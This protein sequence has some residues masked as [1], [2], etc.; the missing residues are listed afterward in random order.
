VLAI[1]LVAGTAIVLGQFGAAG[2]QE[3]PAQ[4]QP[5]VAPEAKPA[6]AAAGTDAGP[7]STSGEQAPAQSQPV[8]EKSTPAGEPARPPQER[9]EPTEK[10][11]ADFDVSFPVDI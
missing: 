6:T 8:G 1:T 3:S 9:F 2:A 11:R 10:V 5:A 7:A 4:P